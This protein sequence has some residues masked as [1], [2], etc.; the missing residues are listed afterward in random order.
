MI[1]NSDPLG[2]I[3]TAKKA[4]EIFKQGQKNATPE[5]RAAWEKQTYQH[6]WKN[7]A[8]MFIF[9]LITGGAL[10]AEMAYRHQ[11]F[12]PIAWFIAVAVTG[13][14]FLLGVASVIGYLWKIIQGSP[15]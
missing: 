12:D 5:Q 1:R 7:L 9:S 14:L 8:G 11:F 13:F 2:T 6:R 15:E 4:F 10:Y 3:R